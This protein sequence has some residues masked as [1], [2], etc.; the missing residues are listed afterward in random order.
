[1][2]STYL[3]LLSVLIL[4][5]VQTNAQT[6]KPKYKFSHYVSGSPAA[7]A[8]FH[9]PGAPKHQWIFRPT[10][11]PA[12]PES[13][14]TSV[15]LRVGREYNQFTPNP[16]VYNDIRIKMGYTKDTS[17]IRK[18]GATYDSFKTILTLSIISPPLPSMGLILWVPGYALV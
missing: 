14:I 4:A 6:Q 9:D 1:M 7:A 8:D 3:R 2:Q 16:T 15:Y 11:L 13:S 10:E 5:T 18:A 17:F 12:L